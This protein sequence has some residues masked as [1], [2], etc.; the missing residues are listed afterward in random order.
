MQTVHMIPESQ[1]ASFVE[2]ELPCAEY[3]SSSWR[4]VGGLQIDVQTSAVEVSVVC[5]GSS[6]AGRRG[7]APDFPE[8]LIPRIL[9]QP[10]RDATAQA[11][12]EGGFA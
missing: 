11:R 1:A 6:V 7:V 4:H 10:A 2:T 12:E 5:P 8:D 9:L 3:S